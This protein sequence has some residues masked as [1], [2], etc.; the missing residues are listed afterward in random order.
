MDFDFSLE[1]SDEV[2]AIGAS[3]DQL[4]DGLAVFGD[5]QTVRI[6]VIEQGKALFLELRGADLGGRGPIVAEW[7]DIMTSHSL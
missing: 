3:R 7:S 6:E 4:G 2:L 5:D 1:A